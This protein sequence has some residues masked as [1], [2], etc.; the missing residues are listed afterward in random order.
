MAR[1]SRD[2]KAVE[3]NPAA[4]IE[5]DKHTHARGA[6]GPFTNILPAHPLRFRVGEEQAAQ[7]QRQ[8]PATLADVHTQLAAPD[9][10]LRLLETSAAPPH[11][12][13]GGVG[14]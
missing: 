13:R 14:A 6:V 4:R 9:P 10:S 12:P 11:S 8:A 1:I 5:S 7:Y 2:K 3:A